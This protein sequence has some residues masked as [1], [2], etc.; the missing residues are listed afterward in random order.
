MQ[1][2]E[3][4]L[5]SKVCPYALTRFSFPFS[6]TSLNP[7]E[8]RKK[9]NIRREFIKGT[10]DSSNFPHICR[11]DIWFTNP[12]SHYN[13]VLAKVGTFANVWA[14][15]RLLPPF[16]LSFSPFHDLGFDDQLF[17]FRADTP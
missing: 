5:K 1:V 10:M 2:R 11:L 13:A 12:E 9:L 8:I 6:N 4:Q 16:R 15:V 7:T 14:S 3:T 17:L